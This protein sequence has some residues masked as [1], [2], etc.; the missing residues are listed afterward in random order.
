MP[1]ATL[2]L[3]VL[4]FSLGGCASVQPEGGVVAVEA[5]RVPGNGKAQVGMAYFDFTATALDGEEVRLSEF[6]GR[7]VVLLQFWGIRCGPCLEE[8]PFLSGLQDR[9]GETGLQVFGINTDRV[10]AVQLAKAMESRQIRAS[11]P[12]VLDPDFSISQHYTNWLIPVSVLIDR[13][14]VVAAIHTGY[15]PEMDG[16]IEGEVARLLEE[17]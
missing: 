14:G 3:F 5:P 1:R 13:R 12:V 10:S 16:L 8:I 15:K 6:V 11:Y 4:W 2:I 17:E 9:Y 7:S